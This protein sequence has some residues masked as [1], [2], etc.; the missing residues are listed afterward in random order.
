MMLAVLKAGARALPEELKAF[1]QSF[2]DSGKIPRYGLPD[3]YEIVAEIPK[4]SVGKI[5]KVKLREMY[6]K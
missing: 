3:R 4:T 5:N 2:V 6:S 1:M